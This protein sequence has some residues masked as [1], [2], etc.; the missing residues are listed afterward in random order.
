MFV[1]F[2]LDLFSSVPELAWSKAGRA[3][4][5]VASCSLRFSSVFIIFSRVA[6]VLSSLSASPPHVETQPNDLRVDKKKKKKKKV[7]F[8]KVELELRVPW[9]LQGDE[10]HMFLWQGGP[11]PHQKPSWS[12]TL[13]KRLLGARG[14]PKC[15]AQISLFTLCVT[16]SVRFVMEKFTVCNKHFS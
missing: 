8:F 11:R 9:M 6:V 4:V 12:S 1:G 3:Q 5:V 2:A 14:N 7:L 13:V 15:F 10:V 16:V